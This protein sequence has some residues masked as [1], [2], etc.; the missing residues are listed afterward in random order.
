MAP[1]SPQVSLCCTW[2][3]NSGFGGGGGLLERN[4][5]ERVG[6]TRNGFRN[7]QYGSYSK[8]L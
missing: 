4:L 5:I 1:V 7:T 2:R 3:V 8:T 6:L